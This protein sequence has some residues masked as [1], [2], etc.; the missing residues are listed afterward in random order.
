MKVTPKL[1][2]AARR[3]RFAVHGYADT[4]PVGK[5]RHKPKRRVAA[6]KL[7]YSGTCR[8]LKFGS[9]SLWKISS[10]SYTFPRQCAYGVGLFLF[11]EE[12]Y[13]IFGIEVSNSV[14]VRG[15]K[16]IVKERADAAF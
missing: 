3:D 16:T 15:K 9:K 5:H 12:E 7:R 2:I 6:Y 10:R 13:E 1:S 4:F 14:P 11:I 8:P